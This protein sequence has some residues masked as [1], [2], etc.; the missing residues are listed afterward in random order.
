MVIFVHVSGALVVRLECNVLPAN[1]WD[2]KY[3]SDKLQVDLTQI[4]GDA[5]NG[6][7]ATLK[8][9]QLNIQNSTGNAVIAYSTGSNGHGIAAAGNGTGSGIAGTGGTTGKG[10]IATG[11]SISGAGIYAW[12]QGNNDAGMELVKH[13]TGKDIDADETDSILADTAEIGVAGAGLTAVPWNSNWDAEVQSECTDALNAYDPPTKTEMDTAHSTTDGK[14]DALNDLSAAQVNAEVDTALNT[15]IPASPT[16]DSI[17]ERVKAIDDKLPTNYIM[18]SSVQTAKDDEIDAI[19]AKT[20]NLPADP[21]SETNVDANETKID[22]IDTVVDAIKAKTDNLPA[23]PA[24]VGSEMGL[25][26]DAI[27]SAKFDESTAFPVKSADTG[28]TQIARVGADGD[29]LETLSDQLDAVETDTQDIQTK[30]GTPANLDTGGATIS[31]N[32]KK[33]ADDNGGADFDATNHSLK[34]IRTQG[35]AAWVTDIGGSIAHTYTVL[36]D[37]GNPIPEVR[38]EA[39]SGS[40]HVQTVYT[41]VNGQAV[42]HLDA[43]TYDFIARKLGYSFTNPD[44][45]VVS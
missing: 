6:N 1:I 16:A 23:S 36:D 7:N 13:G 41:D 33:I 30:I 14:I 17:N 5:T 44:T 27:T 4:N 38:V 45:E 42:F 43:G 11:G 35:D 19:K 15:A 29:T 12:A 22:T 8:L 40:T 20:D 32:L 9:K 21:A 24:A 2:S 18:G 34:A 28:A 10:V 39:W 3:G 26:N 25:S 37:D 31:D